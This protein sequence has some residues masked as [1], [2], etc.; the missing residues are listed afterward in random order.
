MDDPAFRST[1]WE[2]SGYGRWSEVLA[3]G[4]ILQSAV[5]DLPAKERPA[6]ESHGVVSLTEFPVFVGGEWWGAIGFDDCEGVREW[7]SDELSALRAS[8]TVLGAA[9]QR[10][11]LTRS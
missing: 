6:L 7:S 4:E 10:H 8:A 9:V 5:A 11:R 3:R 2:E 1:S